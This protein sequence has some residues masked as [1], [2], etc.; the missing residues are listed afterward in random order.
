MPLTK[1]LQFV[2][3]AILFAAAFRPFWARGRGD[4][5]S[6]WPTLGA[7]TLSSAGLAVSLTL[8]GWHTDFGTALWAT[9]AASC[10]VFAAIALVNVQ[11][12]G[13]MVLLMPYLAVLG[14]LGTLVQGEPFAMTSAPA[15]WLDIHIGLAVAVT[16]FLTVAAVSSTALSLQER[17]LKYKQTRWYQ[18]VLPSVNDAEMLS[19]RL[20]LLVE[21]LLA[22]GLASGMALNYLQ[23]GVLL[24][25]DHKTLLSIIA[26]FLIGALLI[27]HRVCGVR[28]R[29][30]ARVVLAAYL[31]V[32]LASAGVKF[33]TQVLL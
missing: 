27:G 17:A 1:I 14:V 9:V 21:V 31:L 7:V 16:G 5:T 23:T 3:L 26:F 2:A 4:G 28:G 15:A 13:L 18:P 33:I 30:A 8:S 12:R 10:V 25:L 29:M 11:A 24:K 32:M 6:Y 19:G 20:L 22:V